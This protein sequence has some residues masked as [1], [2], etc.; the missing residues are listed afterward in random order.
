VK[1][2]R[3]V[4][5]SIEQ[6]VRLHVRRNPDEK[7]ANL[8]ARLKEC[9]TA[10]LR[11]EHCECGEPIWVIGSAVAG[12]ACFTCITGEATPSGD[13]EIDEVLDVKCGNQPNR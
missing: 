6:Y 11:G 7:R 4:P 8:R 13:Y 2:P 9:V 5:I 10:A 3:F 1:H 12:H